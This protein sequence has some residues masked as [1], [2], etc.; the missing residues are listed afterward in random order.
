MNTLK[1]IFTEVYDILGESQTSTIFDKSRIIREINQATLDVCKG[2]IINEL[3]NLPIRAGMLPFLHLSDIY[4]IPTVKTL[5]INASFGETQLFLSDIE[6][7]ETEGYVKVFG[8]FLEYTSLDTASNAIVLSEPLTKAILAGE[9][10]R[11]VIKKDIKT[12]KPRDIREYKT[13]R[14]LTYYNFQDVPLNTNISYTIEPYKNDEYVIFDNFTGLVVIPT[15][16]KPTD[17]QEDEAICILP[18]DYGKKVVAPLVAGKE[19]KRDSQFQKGNDSL[20]E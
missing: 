13:N 16:L 4:T 17:M 1:D 7:M 9:D 20:L 2:E 15:I 5:I 12:I 19:L 18:D 3:T 10:V 8:K 6:G 14:K 11:S